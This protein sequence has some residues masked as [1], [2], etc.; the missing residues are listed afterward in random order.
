MLRVNGVTGVCPPARL[1]FTC[2]RERSACKPRDQV[3]GRAQGGGE[4]LGQ[5]VLRLASPRIRIRRIE[6]ERS[7]MSH[8]GAWRS[9]HA[10][11]IER[12]SAVREAGG[13]RCRNVVR[14]RG[15]AATP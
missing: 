5:A 9:C 10:A 2:T 11:T 8:R 1:R 13:E 12:P 6:Q 15:G 4:Y 14:M 3:G 7:V